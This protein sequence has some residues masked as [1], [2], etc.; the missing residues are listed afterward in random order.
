MKLVIRFDT[1]E[2]IEIVKEKI[3]PSTKGTN[4]EP[5]RF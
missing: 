2:K 3:A 5:I 4:P 1:Q